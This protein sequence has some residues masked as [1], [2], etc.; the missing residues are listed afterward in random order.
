MPI[1]RLSTG[2]A[3]AVYVSFTRDEP[4]AYAAGSFGCTLRFVSKEVDPTNDEPEEE[5][6]QDEYQ[7]EDCDLG[8]GDYI[9]PTYATFATEWD[10][11][12][13]ASSITETFALSSSESLK[14]A[15]KSLIEVL[16]MEALGGTESPTSNTVHTLNLSGIVSGGGGKVLARCRMTFAPGS[17]VTLELAVR[18]EKDEV[19]RL[20]M[21]AI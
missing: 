4:S 19:G 15:C 20:V 12:A 7:V 14:D 11:L 10:K 13:G 17:G 6:Y 8:A 9:T 18:A 2:G 16:N 5:G 21:A 1:P 3:G